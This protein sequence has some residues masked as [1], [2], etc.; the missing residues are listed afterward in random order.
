MLFIATPTF[1]SKSDGA[2]CFARSSP[3]ERKVQIRKLYYRKSAE[4]RPW[5]VKSV[6]DATP[7][8]EVEFCLHRSN[9]EYLHVG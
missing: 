5:G 8:E 9:G 6:L 3:R 7:Q 2:L 4:D 1:L